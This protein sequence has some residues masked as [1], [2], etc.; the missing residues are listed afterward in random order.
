MV[1][2][3]RQLVNNGKQ[4]RVQTLSFS[5]EKR[6]NMTITDKLNNKK[7]IVTKWKTLILD[8]YGFING[9]KRQSYHASCA[10]LF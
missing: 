9:I 2:L 5:S 6:L 1:F 3:K 8:D 4:T 7:D 10:F